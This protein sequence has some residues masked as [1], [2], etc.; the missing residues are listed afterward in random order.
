MRPGRADLRRHVF[1]R[2]GWHQSRLSQLHGRRDAKPAGRGSEGG[3]ARE[4]SRI[5]GDGERR[6]CFRGPFRRAAGYSGGPARR[7]RRCGTGCGGSGGDGE[8]AGSGAARPGDDLHDARSIPRHATNADPFQSGRP[9]LC[10]GRGR[11]DRDGQSCRANGTGDNG[12]H[13]AAGH[14]GEQCGCARCTVQVCGGDVVGTRQ[15]GR[16]EDSWKRTRRAKAS[17][18]FRRA[19]ANST[20]WTRHLEGSPR[21]WCAATRLARGPRWACSASI[22]RISGRRARSMNRSKRSATTCI[23]SF[24]CDRRRGRLH[25]G[26][27]ASGG[28]PTR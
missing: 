27:T 28:G 13:F 2:Q 26:C 24:P 5:G 16:T 11:R 4:R 6:D 12:H 20:S 15:G 8:G 10:S 7:R 22:S 25:L 21:C 9:A 14:T 18:R 19:K 17:P 1:E 3:G 23:A